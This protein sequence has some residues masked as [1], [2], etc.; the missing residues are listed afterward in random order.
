[1]GED[2]IAKKYEENSKDPHIVLD[3]VK[4]LLK[5]SVGDFT[6]DEDSTSIRNVD[7]VL[8]VLYKA[9]DE[10]DFSDC[11]EIG[12]QFCLIIYSLESRVDE[13]GWDDGDRNTARAFA[14]KAEDYGII[15]R[16]LY[17]TQAKAEYHLGNFTDAVKRAQLAFTVEP[18]SEEEKELFSDKVIEDFI[19][20]C[21]STITK[22]CVYG[23][24]KN[25]ANSIDEWLESVKGANF[26]FLA[27]IGSTDGTLDKLQEYRYKNADHFDYLNY[28]SLFSL[29]ADNFSFASIRNETLSHAKLSIFSQYPG[30]RAS[31]KGLNDWVYVSLDVG[32]YL[33]DEAISDIRES[34]TPGLYDTMLVEY[35]DHNKQ[36]DS[37]APVKDLIHSNDSRW[38]WHGS[39]NEYIKL[40]GV[41][42]DDE[43][44]LVI[45]PPI[46]YVVPNHD[47]K[48]YKDIDTYKALRRDYDSQ[49][50]HDST[51]LMQLGNEALYHKENGKAAN[52][53]KECYD[54]ITS[55]QKDDNYMNYS[56]MAYCCMGVIEFTDGLDL[57]VGVQY[58]DKL[59]HMIYEKLIPDNR[60]V[61][62][63]LSLL[64][65]MAYPLLTDKD[66]LQLAIDELEAAL[67]IKSK[68]DGCW[69]DSD[70]LYKDNLSIY[71]NLVSYYSLLYDRSGDINYLETA[72]S[73]GDIAL[74]ENKDN[75]RL[76]KS[77][78]NFSIKNCREQYKD[79]FKNN[80]ANIKHEGPDK[81]CVYAITKNESKFVERW[82]NSMKEA[83]SIVVLDTGSTDD[84]VQKLRDLG[85]I[86][87]QKEYGDLWR[88]DIARNDA[89][90]MAPDDCNILVSTDLDEFF[91][92]GWADILRKD[93]SLGNYERVEYAYSWSHLE[94]GEDGRVFAYNKIHSRNWM[95]KYPVHELLINIY[96]DSEN[97]EY[98]QLLNLFGDIH[99]HH[100]PDQTKS[101]G[102]YLGLLELRASA[103]KEDWYGLIYLAH[104]Y[105]YRGYYQKSIDEF[106]YIL[107]NYSTHYSQLEKASCYLFMGDDYSKL[108]NPEKAIDNYIKAIQVDKTYRE[109]YIGLANQYMSINDLEKAKATLKDAISKTYRHYTWL[110]RDT[111]WTYEVYDLLCL[112]CYYSGDKKDS[113]LY[114]AKALSYE[115]E[116][117]R[118][119]NNLKLC[120][121]NTPDSKLV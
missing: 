71:S 108:K 6:L 20:K 18:A 10:C 42:E 28:N 68:P 73:Y 76:D 114:A 24:C 81:I 77:I 9:I 59:Q 91:E 69:F 86:V 38:K 19:K 50:I 58:G 31:K 35:L 116:N 62:D 40:D 1:M 75:E 83:D 74:L 15:T 32:S 23:I 113:I 55:N 115:P 65:Y 110:E 72:I 92:P 103:Y 109:P 94:N 67:K 49:V 46:A 43:R 13:D 87:H 56:Y 37:Y 60:K 36:F 33:D 52:Y 88:F 99:L 98:N 45:N 30:Y 80:F 41:K 100:Y 106:N 48:K 117:E 26:V 11:K 104:E 97:Y 95:W 25:D 70:N 79:Y 66:Y 85:V 12:Y 120:I 105:Y 34:W 112:A 39:V 111:S 107:N 64:Y 102:S 21:N 57:S 90:L 54:I 119:K 16:R 93:W 27:D 47:H 101:R 5:Q 61:R 2:N 7:D 51:T 53:F 118:L 22:V 44:T 63:C 14:Y 8:E 4:E 84:T 3:Y 17:M 78:I 29:D 89:M 82:Y 96:T 121:E